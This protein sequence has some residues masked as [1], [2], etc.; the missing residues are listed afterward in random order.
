MRM[1]DDICYKTVIHGCGAYCNNV[2]SDDEIILTGINT[3][4]EYPK[5][6][7]LVTVWNKKKQEE[8]KIPT[9]NFKEDEERSCLY[10][11]WALDAL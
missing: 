2:R 11:V 6:I 8:I 7:R 5:K 9:N 3:R 10:S 1:K 4:N